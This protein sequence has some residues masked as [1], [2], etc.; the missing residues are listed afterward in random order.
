MEGS[1]AQR[2]CKAGHGQP[3]DARGTV[4]DRLENEA[5]GAFLFGD[6]TPLGPA[7]P[8]DRSQVRGQQ[9]QESPLT[10]GGAVS[11]EI[12]ASPVLGAQDIQRVLRRGMQSQVR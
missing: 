12:R 2:L 4:S 10:R 6:Q 11:G 5:V 7:L 8:N 1:D 3:P 9:S